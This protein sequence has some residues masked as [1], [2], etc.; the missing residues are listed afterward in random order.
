MNYVVGLSKEGWYIFKNLCTEI[1]VLL[2]GYFTF[3]PAV[4]VSSFKLFY[5]VL[6]LAA[7][8]S[9][10]SFWGGLFFFFF[11]DDKISTLLKKNIKNI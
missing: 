2:S 7:N 6:V 1:A 3:V 11:N 9:S 4:Q 8:N 5:N 10:I